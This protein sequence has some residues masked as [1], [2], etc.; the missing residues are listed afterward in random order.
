MNISQKIP[1]KKIKDLGKIYQNQILEI[2]SNNV[3]NIDFKLVYY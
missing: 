2:S 3:P 1:N